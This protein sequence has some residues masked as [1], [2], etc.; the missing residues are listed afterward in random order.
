MF[1]NS[2]Y[3]YTIDD[4]AVDGEDSHDL[5]VNTTKPEERQSTPERLAIHQIMNECIF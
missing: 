1:L 4:D 2:Q 3:Y 5:G